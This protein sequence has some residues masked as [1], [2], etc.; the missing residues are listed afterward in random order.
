MIAILPMYDWPGLRDRTDAFWAAVSARLRDADI[1]A[2]EALTRSADPAASWRDPDLLLGQTC[3]MP[4][5]SGLCGDAVIVGRPD[6]GLQE[7]SFGFYRSVIVVRE[8]DLRAGGLRTGGL[9]AWAGCRVA[10]NEWRS[11]SGHIAPR[12]HLAGL[13]GEASCGARKPF[14]GAAVISGGHRDSAR[15]VAQGAADLAALDGVVWALLQAE[16]PETAR[17]LAVIDQT[18]P[19]PA[20]PFITAARHAG[21]REQLTAALAGAAAALAFVPGLP[22]TVAVASGDDYLP[23]RAAARRAAGEAFAPEAPPVPA[24]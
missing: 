12:A 1:A 5:V 16:E 2:P 3:G 15:M 11:Y 22:C 20:L 6:Y 4:F 19:A 9:S 10:V 24:V 23:V 21:L 7:A 8:A 13:Q 18:E 14:F 17:R